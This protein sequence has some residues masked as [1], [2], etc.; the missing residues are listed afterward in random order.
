MSGIDM[1]GHFMPAPA[2]ILAKLISQAQ[3]S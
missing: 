2:K 3:S 1:K